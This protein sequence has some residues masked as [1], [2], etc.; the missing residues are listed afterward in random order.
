MRDILV[1]LSY[2]LIPFVF[3]REY[4]MIKIAYWVML[5]G[6]Q[7]SLWLN[8][9]GKPSLMDIAEG[10]SHDSPYYFILRLKILEANQSIDVRFEIREPE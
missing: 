6:S 10:K 9:G 7:V 2:A 3:L 4:L 8:Y 1:R 5:V